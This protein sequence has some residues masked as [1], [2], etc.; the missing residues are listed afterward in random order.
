MVF[1]KVIILAGGKG[2]RLWPLSRESFPK[3][4][5]HFGDRLSLLQKTILRFS[6]AYSSEDIV[7]LT[8][9]NYYHIVCSQC[10]EIDSDFTY[11]ILIEPESKNTAAAIALGAKYLQELKGV[12]EDDVFLVAPSDHLL[13][14]ESAFL[15]LLPLAEVHAKLGHILTFGVYP[16]APE[17]GYGYI[18]YIQEEQSDVCTVQ[19]FIEKP[20]LDRAQSYLLS[21]D[22]LWNSGIFVF[23][24]TTFWK[25][26][27]LYAPAISDL[28]E[29]SFAQSVVRFSEAIDISIDHALLEKSQVVKVIPMHLS[30]S[31]VGSWDSVYA[32][33]EKDSASNVKVGNIIDID[34]KNCLIFGGKRLISTIGL[35]DML[36]IET[37][38][39]LL[40]SK[41]GHSQKVKALVQ[42]LTSNKMDQSIEHLTSH[43][44]WG[45][46]TIL[47]EGYR[48]KI[49]K[50][51]V[52]PHQRLSLQLHYHRSE[53]WVV[54]RGTAKVRIGDEESILL[55]NE[56]I[57]VP[58][59]K[60]HRLENPGK[61]TL[62]LIEVQVGEYVGEDDIVRIQDDYARV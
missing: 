61:I 30:W 45:S 13:H 58:K 24:M 23:S 41:K 55:E 14:P 35:E 20:S 19:A 28:F 37:S 60:E 15:S 62:E 44:P 53:H 17:T 11:T 21:G 16:N 39:A 46:Y 34:T 25:E 22:Y 50:I 1:M 8:N 42:Q 2:T 5:L 26:L 7:I 3:Q 18:K 32:S 29:G 43:R 27:Q 56:S 48:Y 40:V 31:D 6:A 12:T 10:K 38:D 49:K 59:S 47:E 54:V 4:F 33:M 52:H 36:I 57:F 9:Q 51:S